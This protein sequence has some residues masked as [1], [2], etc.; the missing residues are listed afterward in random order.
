M[1]LRLTATDHVYVCVVD[2]TGKAV[3][4]GVYLEKGQQTK[5]FRSKRFRANFGNGAVR[6]IVDGKTLPRGQHR[7]ARRLRDAAGQEAAQLSES[8]RAGLC[9]L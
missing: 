8:V 7:H 6:M 3:V 4:N 9:A 1:T 5:T 2:A